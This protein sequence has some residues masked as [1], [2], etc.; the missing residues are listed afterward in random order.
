MKH[1]AYLVLGA[2]HP[3][4]PCVGG[5]DAVRRGSSTEAET[6]GADEVAQSLPA[7][8]ELSLWV[9]C[10]GKLYVQGLRSPEN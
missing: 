3:R 9:H 2:H 8:T 10:D 6:A 1:R 7:D 5:G 4:L